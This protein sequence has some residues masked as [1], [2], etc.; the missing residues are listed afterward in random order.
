M[1]LQ[2]QDFMAQ[3][4]AILDALKQATQSGQP[5]AQPEQ[6]AMPMMGEGGPPMGE[7][8]PMDGGGLPPM[9]MAPDDGLPPMGVAPDDDGLP[10]TIEIG[11]AVAPA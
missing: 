10:P 2:M 1:Y 6:G 8:P 7:M 3:L 11:G 5:G 4:P 9:E